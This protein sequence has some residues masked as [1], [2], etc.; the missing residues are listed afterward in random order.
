MKDL[1]FSKVDFLGTFQGFSDHVIGLGAAFMALARGASIIE[2]HFAIDHE[3]GVDAAW[4][5]TPPELKG[6]RH[7]ADSC[8]EAL[9]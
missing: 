5:M 2:K 6:L 3:T 8:S 7:F 1:H 9:W 4:S